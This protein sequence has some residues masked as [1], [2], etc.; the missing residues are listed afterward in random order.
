MKKLFL[1]LV[2][3]S[4]GLISTGVEAFDH[5]HEDFSSVLKEFVSLVNDRSVVDYK[6]LKEQP[7]GLDGYLASLQSV[8]P[9]EF[10]TFTKD[11]QLAFL[12]NAYNGFTLKLIISHY[13][14]S[15]IKKIGGISGPWKV[16]FFEL[17][18]ERKHLDDIEHNMIRK[19]F[20][21]PR[22]H[23]AVNC[24]SRGC[25]DLASTAYEANSLESQLEE[26]TRNFL[27]DSSLNRLSTNEKQLEVSSIFTWFKNDFI[28]AS[29]S[30]QNFLTIYVPLTLEQKSKVLSGEIGLKFLDYDWSLNETNQ[31]TGN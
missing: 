25:P 7:G 12:I 5:T 9:E 1:T 10:R 29:G 3:M 26:A 24:A 19:M 6:A 13:P 17:L 21:E 15:S 23:F 11:Q 30:L 16:K 4:F 22:I 8:T 2:F 20:K 28:S 27:R 18:G 31:E 14:V